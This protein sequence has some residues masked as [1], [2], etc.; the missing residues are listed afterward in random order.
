MMQSHRPAAQRRCKAI[1]VCSLEQ[2]NKKKFSYR[3]IIIPISQLEMEQVYPSTFANLLRRISSSQMDDHHNTRATCSTGTRGIF[4]VK[5][6][7]ISARVSILQLTLTARRHL[8]RQ[9]WRRK[10]P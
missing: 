9:K 1:G 7:L 2:V 5:R 3:L 6:L 10:Q 8:Q 4:L